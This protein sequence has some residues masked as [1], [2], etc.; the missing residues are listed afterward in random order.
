MKGRIYDRKIF[1]GWYIVIASAILMGVSWGI[2]LNTAS[3]FVNPISSDLEISRKLMN[4]T[5]SIR[6]LTQLTI[7]LLFGIILTRFKLSNLMK[8]S[9]IVSVLSLYLHSHIESLGSLYLLTATLG[10]STILL[11]T[12]PLSVIIN[13]WFYKKNGTA[14]GIAF[15]GSGIGGMI[16][17]YLVGK[18]ISLYDWRIAYQLLALIFLLSAVPIVFLVLKVNPKDIG[19]SAF[20]LDKA[21][22]PSIKGS[23]KED[24]PGVMLVDAKKTSHFWLLCLT[25]TMFAIPG[26]AF[27]NSV[28]PHLIDIGYSPTSSANIVA[29]S[30]GILALGKIVLGY[31]FDRLGLRISTFISSIAVILGLICLLNADQY[32]LI[33]LLIICVGLGSPY[34]T[35]A[36]PIIT[37][38]LYGK[39]DYNSIYGI[40]NVAHSMGNII[41]P[42]I[43]GYFYDKSGSYDLSFMIMIV[44]SV[45]GMVSYQ[46]LFRKIKS[47]LE[48]V[49]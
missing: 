33:G 45:I 19:L 9:S 29:L 21:E 27:L 15:M 10:V 43:I 11:G 48:K 16:F 22:Y 42:L 26:N 40:F 12:M 7:S 4:V 31:M 17:N 38:K 24:I 3:L 6:S 30:M 35:V 18:W 44:F 20:G 1:Y 25:I 46:A 23:D 47:P 28:A 5:F 37:Q 34:L 13:N 2:T 49:S 32:I 14:L 36:Y 8:L 41:S 39:K